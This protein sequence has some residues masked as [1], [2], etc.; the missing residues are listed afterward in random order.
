[1]PG[2]AFFGDVQRTPI[3]L[4]TPRWVSL[5]PTCSWSQWAIV[6][7]PKKDISRPKPSSRQ[8]GLPLVDCSGV[9]FHRE[10]VF[11]FCTFRADKSINLGFFTPPLSSSPCQ[12]AKTRPRG[13]AAPPPRVA[14]RRR[15]LRSAGRSWRNRRRSFGPSKRRTEGHRATR[16]S[17]PGAQRNRF[18]FGEGSPTKID[19]KE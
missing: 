16:S 13:A 3:C 14:L 19:R 2:P 9:T 1:M 7:V 15:R 18:F 11:H 17:Q 12:K 6:G 5:F 10:S 8:R 4:I